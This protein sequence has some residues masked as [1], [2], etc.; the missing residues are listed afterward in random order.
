MASRTRKAGA[1]S[2]A[3]NLG[4]PR[5][6]L[7]A[8]RGL[9]GGRE[10]AM[11]LGLARWPGAR[12]LFVNSLGVG[13]D[14]VVAAGAARQGGSGTLPYLRAV[15]SS[16]RSYRPVDVVVEADGR[17]RY[18]GLAAAIVVSN[19]PHAGGGMRLAP[20]ADLADGAL[21]LVE[22]GALG[23]WEL[24]CWLPTLYWGGHVRH[25]QVRMTRARG[26]RIAS[27]AP[28][29]LELDGEACGRVPVVDVRVCGGALRLRR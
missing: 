24:L 14:A 18:S 19:G 10:V 4:V 1:G 27:G 16:L 11:D 28:L 21:D 3:R 20:G 15:V 17:A 25:P 8:A 9:A 5:D 13:F 23:R 6:P 22:I 2:S 26:I 29:P 7:A 12:R